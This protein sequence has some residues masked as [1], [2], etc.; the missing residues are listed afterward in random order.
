MIE[1]SNLALGYNG[2]VALRVADLTLGQ[3]EHWLVCGPSGRGKT[4]L[5]YALA[6]LLPPLQGRLHVA[7]TE[8]STLSEAA[9]D[10]F[11][12]RHIG[13]VFQSLHLVPALSVIENL[14]L[15]SY[16][17]GLPQNHKRA[18]SLLDRLGLAGKHDVLPSALSQGQ[19]QRVA[20]ARAV[21]HRPDLLLADEPTASL[22]DEAATNV[23]AL[24]REAAK[25][26][27]ATLVISTHDARV[28]SQFEHR[29]ELGAA[30]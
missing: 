29:L 3:G 5:L 6:G 26:Q 22:D 28:K 30:A 16:L 20:I 1:W 19:A 27:G 13:L 17:A 25:E 10:L 24:L 12:G 2:N 11:R 9:R 21:L 8:L 23:I 4:T 14:L 18:V 15:A 7:G